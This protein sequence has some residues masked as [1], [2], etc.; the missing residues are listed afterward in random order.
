MQISPYPTKILKLSYALGF[1]PY[2]AS[3]YPR[4][5]NIHKVAIFIGHN[6]TLTAVQNTVCEVDSS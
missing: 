6:K 1:L 3:I 5:Q 4:Y 2:S